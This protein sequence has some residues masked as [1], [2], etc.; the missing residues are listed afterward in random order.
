M[1]PLPQTKLQIRLLRSQ[2]HGGVHDKYNVNNKMKQ[3]QIQVT[4]N[5]VYVLIAGAVILMFFIG[6]VVRQQSISEER[7]AVDV[8]E[9]MESIFTG[10]EVSEKTKNV[11]DTSGLVDYTFY[12]SC[13][14][15]VTEYGIEGTSA[16]I[17]NNVDSIFT[18]NTL[19]TAE[20]IAWSL[21]YNLPYKITDFLFITSSNTKYVVL[22][23]TP[24]ALEFID[25][26]KEFNVEQGL[27]ELE[28]GDNYQFR[29]IDTTGVEIQ[30]GRKTPSALR[31]VNDDRVTAV[32]FTGSEGGTRVEYFQKQGITWRSQG[33]PMPIVSL[34]GKRD[35]AK[36]AAIFAGSAEMYWCGMQKAF[37]R[38]QNINKI[39]AAKLQTFETFYENQTFGSCLGYI[40]GSIDQNMKQPL[41]LQPSQAEFCSRQQQCQDLLESSAKIQEVNDLMRGGSCTPIY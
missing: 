38:L 31:D 22:G 4:F 20:L 30:D 16:G 15:K 37:T 36:Y 27:E 33:R 32:S 23:Q 19:Q 29:I 13:F 7:L 12:F 18:P 21:P 2:V 39:Q 6:L 24:F 10:A 14:D 25:S 41:L 3:G 9:I 17:Q 34:G 40:S 8:I 1:H 35:A 26:T 11:I 5:W 28:A